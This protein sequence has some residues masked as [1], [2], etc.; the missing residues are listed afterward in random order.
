MLDLENV[1]MYF[2]KNIALDKINLHLEHGVYGLLGPNGA[3]KTTL[4]RCIA[5]ILRSSNGKISGADHIG[6]LPQ[7]FGMFKELTVL[8]TMEYFAALKNIPRSQYRICAMECLEQ[9]HL[10]ERAKDKVA[11]L[12]GGMVRRLGIAQTLLGSPS[13]ILVDE[14]TAG[15]DPEERLRFKNLISSIRKDRTILISTHIVEDV[16]SVCDH[17]IILHKG[18]ILVQGTAEDIRKR[19]KA[20]FSP[21]PP[22][23]K[24]EL[25]EP[26]FLLRD[27]YVGGEE[28]LRILSQQEQPWKP[29]TP[30]V[31][32]GYMLYIHE[33]L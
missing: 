27:E 23:A 7:K 30:T 29:T 20:G 24:D 14:P 3:G 21:F 9:V 22:H 10:A 19:R 8:E 4:M 25:R 17:I 5:G 15:L 31:E 16:E 12:S 11:S 2:G 28:S 1:S 18:H 6:Y 13:L 33:E 26:Y 32:D